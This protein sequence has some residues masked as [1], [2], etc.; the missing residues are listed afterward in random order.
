MGKNKRFEKKTSVLIIIFVVFAVLS[1]LHLSGV[2]NYLEF[3]SYDLRVRIMA[4][5]SRPSDE[6]VVILLDQHSLDWAQQERGWGWPWPRQSYAE[7]VDY[8]NIAGA[9]SIAFD[10]LF[11]EPS[12]YRSARQDEIID[13]TVRYLETALALRA[14]A[15]SAEEMRTGVRL[16]YGNVI[17]NLLTLSA[18]EDDA[19]FARAGEEFGKVVH[20][21]F[22]SSQTG[23]IRSWPDGLEAPVFQP[24][25]FGSLLYRFDLGEDAGAQFPIPELRETAGALGSVTGRPDPDGIIRRLKPFTLF[26]GKAVPGISLASLKVAGHG[27]QISYNERKNV[28]EWE[29]FSIPVNKNGEA[30][31]RYRGELSRYWPYSAMDILISAE[32]YSKGEEPLI[33][34]YYFENAYVFFGFFAPGLYDIFSSPISTLYPGIGC[35]ITMLDNILRGDFIRESSLLFNLIILLITV[36]SIIILTMFSNRIS[37]AVGG[38]ILLVVII[39]AAS[40]GAYHWNGLWIPMITYLAG[41]LAAFI[42]V[43]LYN[44]ATEGSQKRFIK[45]AFSQ[46]LSPKVIEQI[47]HDPSQLKLGGEKRE[48]TAIFTDIRAFSTISEALGDPAKLV[49]LL[50][51]YLT[52]MSNI[53]LDNQGTIDKYE[54]DAIIAFFGAPVHMSNNASLACRA[55]ITM[56]KAEADINREALANALITREVM[57]ALAKNRVINSINDP[58]P[59]FTRL[60]IN[61]GDMVVGNMGTPSKMDYTIM[62]NAVNLAARLEGVNKQYN[63]GGILISEYTKQQ[64]ATHGT[65]NEFIM[66]P[67]SKVRVVGVNK[68]LRLYELLDTASEAAPELSAM[69]KSWEHALE[70]YEKHDFS[71][72]KG[73]FQLI[74]DNN[75]TDLV[76]K[77]YLARCEKCLTSPPDEKTWDNGV[78]NLTE[79]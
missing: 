10:V 46:Y 21:V 23:N 5:Y 19:S 38:T 56:K 27:G 74:Y 2:F 40:F 42:T 7:I 76:A 25:N 26:D 8:M 68:P 59:L 14:D 31:L 73:I 78:D 45:S 43:T 3:K 17:N 33:P 47:I 24:E 71:A 9:K 63:T 67:L 51:F 69:V 6:I 15:S 11:S 60:G 30:L 28:L 58:H 44:Y 62:G 52:R 34:P 35:H 37:V 55:A 49:E 22:F 20:A 65:E 66:R 64:I 29:G 70:L 36:T 13:S 61:S 50:N 16:L 75:N 12:V 1:V 32:A 79:K 18:R 48:M 4:K 54:G 72:A 53:I 77:M 41:I 39:I 57:E